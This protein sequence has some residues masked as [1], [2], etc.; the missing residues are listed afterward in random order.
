[1]PVLWT[2]I[3]PTCCCHFYPFIFIFLQTTYI[4]LQ[5]SPLTSLL[6]DSL[7]SIHTALSSSYIPSSMAFNFLP[8]AFHP[9][10]CTSATCCRLGFPTSSHVKW[11][12]SNSPFT[13]CHQHPYKYAFNFA[14]PPSAFL[15]V[16]SFPS[17]CTVFPK[18]DFLTIC[19]SNHTPIYLNK[20]STNSIS[21]VE[22]LCQFIPKSKELNHGLWEYLQNFHH[23][24]EPKCIF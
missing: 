18:A 16:I 22:F 5:P 13:H 4:S 19:W 1:M 9:G 23:F 6:P 24:A 21:L 2:S 17:T 12:S 11:P 3:D 15:H 10:H 20:T 7:I 14:Y 8:R